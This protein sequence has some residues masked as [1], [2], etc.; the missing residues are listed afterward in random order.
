MPLCTIEGREVLETGTFKP[1]KYDRIS[2]GFHLAGHRLRMLA[3][4]TVQNVRK[5]K[6][7]Q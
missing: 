7:S 4:C 5:M 1:S 6:A 2:R 3:K